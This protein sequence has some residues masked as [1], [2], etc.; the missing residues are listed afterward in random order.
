M[1]RG[2]SRQSGGTNGRSEHDPTCIRR[3]RGSEIIARRQCQR[4]RPNCDATIDRQIISSLQG[5]RIRPQTDGIRLAV[6]INRSQVMDRLQHHVGRGRVQHREVEPGH[7]ILCR[8]QVRRQHCGRPAGWGRNRDGEGAD[9]LAVAEH[10]V[11]RIDQERA[12]LAARRREIDGSGQREAGSAGHFHKAAITALPSTFSADLAGHLGR[13]RAQHSDLAAIAL[14]GGVGGNP[15]A[16]LD[17]R[18]RSGQLRRH[19]RATLGAR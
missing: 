7:A 18:F 17:R 2:R 19:A 13:L 6:R 9:R 1:D 3:H 16:G 14:D 8:R 11:V 4:R 15:G 12:D 10:Q 5:K